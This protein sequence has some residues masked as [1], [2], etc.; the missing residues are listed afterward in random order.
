M[1]M[2]QILIEGVDLHKKCFAKKA[3]YRFGFIFI[4]LPESVLKSKNKIFST[5]TSIMHLCSA[6]CT[7]Q[8]SLAADA[9]ESTLS[10]TGEMA[11]TPQDRLVWPPLTPAKKE[12]VKEWIRWGRVCENMHLFMCIPTLWHHS[13]TMFQMESFSV[14]QLSQSSLIMNLRYDS[15]S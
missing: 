13:V 9:S 3:V 12:R 11:V 15:F 10:S 7:G 14:L 4:V 1:T 8:T 6:D 5:H 2:L